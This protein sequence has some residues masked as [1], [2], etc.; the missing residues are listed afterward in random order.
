MERAIKR[1]S[2]NSSKKIYSNELIFFFHRL[3]RRIAVDF[4]IIFLKP[5]LHIHGDFLVC[6]PLLY[7]FHLS[8]LF[9]SRSHLFKAFVPDIL[10]LFYLDH[11]Y[12]LCIQQ[13][14]S[15]RFPFFASR[16]PTRL[17][18]VLF[19]VLLLQ[20]N[21]FV[22]NF[23]LLVFRPINRYFVLSR[24]AYTTYS[25]KWFIFNAGKLKLNF[26]IGKCI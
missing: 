6:F 24:F 25:Y 4:V 14:G 13:F 11:K 12:F 2:R 10:V 17:V 18:S 1:S 5:L 23:S 7:P 20:L 22:F 21:I 9:I 3:N 16:D 8:S 26:Q 15:F 19:A